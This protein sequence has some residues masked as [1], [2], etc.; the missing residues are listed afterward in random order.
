MAGETDLRKL[1][2]AMQPE[3]RGRDWGFANGTPS[4]GL[5]VFATVAE[6]EGMT[7]IAPFADLA[8]LGLNPHGPMARISLTVHSS[9]AAVGL[10]AAIA[11]AL[12]GQGISAN[13]IAGFFHDHI[14][15]AA[16]DADRAMAVLKG[17]CHA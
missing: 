17:L 10:T 7:L 5:A 2:A 9:L 3:L 13:V 16:Q 12:A 14:F 11:T 8:T 4:P 15:V 1:L 6:D